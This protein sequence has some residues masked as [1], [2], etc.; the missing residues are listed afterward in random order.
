MTAAAKCA[1][2]YTPE[3]PRTF[4]EDLD[5]H[6]QTGCV[7][8]TPEW[9]IMARPVDSTAEVALINDPWHEF[10]ADRWDCW[11]IYGYAHTPQM[12]FTGLVEN[13]LRMSPIALPLVAWKRRR[14]ERLRVYAI[15]KIKQTTQ[16]P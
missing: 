5:A 14:D 11:Y 7:F 12:N 2:L 10:P 9:F 13:V 8:N 4:R 15:A 1:A 16:L 6:L 3:S